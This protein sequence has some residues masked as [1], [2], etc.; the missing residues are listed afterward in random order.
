M[1]SRL[2]NAECLL[3]IPIPKSV[4]SN[5]VLKLV[6]ARNASLRWNP[7]CFGC[8]QSVVMMR[9][10]MNGDKVFVRAGLFVGNKPM[11]CVSALTAASS[12][13]STLQASLRFFVD[14]SFSFESDDEPDNWSTG[15]KLKLKVGVVS[16]TVK[17]H[18][19][20]R[21]QDSQSMLDFEW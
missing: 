2:M 6:V 12:I 11:F 3:F 18:T 7:T 5:S 14:P 19:E 17:Q 1:K 16:V 10:M 13:P 4:Q 15:A 9:L 21:L 8:L 20:G